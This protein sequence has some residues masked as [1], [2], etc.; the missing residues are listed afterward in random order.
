MSEMKDR[1]RQLEQRHRASAEHEQQRSLQANSAF[2]PLAVWDALRV[3]QA[4]IGTDA[5][6]NGAVEHLLAVCQPIEQRRRE[7]F[8][9]QSK[10]NVDNDDAEMADGVDLPPEDIKRAQRELHEAQKRHDKMLWRSDD[11]KRHKTEQSAAVGVGNDTFREQAQRSQGRKSL[12]LACP[13]L[14]R[15]LGVVPYFCVF[16]SS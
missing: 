14:T 2:Q 9:A 16:K 7:D 11:A 8:E 5:A 1:H 6:T 4:E 13:L 12:L 15:L 10:P 3:L